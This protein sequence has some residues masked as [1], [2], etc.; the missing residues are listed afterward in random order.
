M[1]DERVARR[2]AD[3]VG[4][5]RTDRSGI[6]PERSNRRAVLQRLVVRTCVGAVPDQDMRGVLG[7]EVHIL[8][9]AAFQSISAFFALPT[10]FT[11]GG[12]IS[13]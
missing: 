9:T 7:P 10:G 5:I 1:R 4:P 3:G 6:A 11:G 13:G 2:D 12:F 8:N